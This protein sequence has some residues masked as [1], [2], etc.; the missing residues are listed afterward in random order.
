MLG[1][2]PTE[3]AGGQPATTACPPDGCYDF[4]TRSRYNRIAGL[5]TESGKLAQGP[6]RRFAAAIR[7]GAWKSGRS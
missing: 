6:L 7:I 3:E 1:E 2:R 4:L 5:E